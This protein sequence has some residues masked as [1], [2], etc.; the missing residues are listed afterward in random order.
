MNAP[1]E[2]DQ[3]E[4]DSEVIA[5]M[6]QPALALE[7]ILATQLELFINVVG[8]PTVRL[9]SPTER[10]YVESWPLRSDL[11][12]AWIAEFVWDQS[13]ILLAEREIDRII[14]V[15]VGKA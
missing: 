1:I 8:Q 6:R 10:P 3:H 7:R 2:A 12:K 4:R 15:L 5:A 14:T 13:C 9:S 11:V